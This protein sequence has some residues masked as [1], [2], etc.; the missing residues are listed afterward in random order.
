[1][2]LL[3]LVL[4]TNTGCIDGTGSD[5]WE[6]GV[7]RF[8]LEPDFEPEVSLCPE[9]DDWGPWGQTDLATWDPDVRPVIEWIIAE[10]GISCSTYVGHDPSI[11]R[12]ADWRPRS[13]E[14]GTRLAN[15]LQDHITGDAAPL[16]L[17]YVMWQAQIGFSSEIRDVEDR[18]S[19]TANHCDHVHMSFYDTIDFRPGDIEPWDDEPEPDAG[20]P[21]EDADPTPED[22]SPPPE[23]TEPPPED[24]SPPPI[25][26]GDDDT[27]PNP[28][29]AAPDALNE[30]DVQ[31]PWDN[32]IRVP[33]RGLS[34]GCGVALSGQST[35]HLL[36]LLIFAP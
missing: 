27:G 20:P 10:T 5:D 1:M 28:L 3:L 16:G 11:G 35:P 33:N 22:S 26:G 32:E 13:R 25:D 18:G 4:S 30:A 36:P 29:D 34:G 24:S 31:N 14:E 8:A 9:T 19:F 12:A 2:L 6:L 21:P 7:E 17:Y 23:D 15:W